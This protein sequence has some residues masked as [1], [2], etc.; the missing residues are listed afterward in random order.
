MAS[1]PSRHR[2]PAE[3]PEGKQFGARG[4]KSATRSMPSSTSAAESAD[5]TSPNPCYSAITAA[6]LNARDCRAWSAVGCDY[7]AGTGH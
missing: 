6:A 1:F 2:W 5:I 7:L 4:L 3:L